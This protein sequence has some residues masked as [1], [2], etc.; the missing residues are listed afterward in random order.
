[1]APLPIVSQSGVANRD[2]F[3]R[4]VDY[5]RL[6]LTD[7]CNLRCTYC[8]PA[9]GV[10]L[11]PRD[12]LLTFEEIWRVAA[13]AQALGFQKFRITGGEPLVVRDIVRFV[14]GLRAVVGSSKIAMTTNAVRLAPLA[15]PLREAGLQLLNISCDTLQADRFARIARRSHLEDMLQGIDAALAAGFERVKLNVVVMPGVNDDEL[16]ALAG[17]AERFDVDVRFIEAMPQMGE[18]RAFVA[19]ETMLDK[20]REAYDLSEVPPK[21]ARQAARMVYTA[22]GL[23]GS[24]AFIAPLTHKFCAQCNRMRLTPYGELKGCLLTP[25]GMGLRDTLRSGISDTNL[26]LL[27]GSAILHKPWAYDDDHHG[28]DRSMSAIGG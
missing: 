17:F 7:R 8:M 25:G 3:G 14:S 13:A 23:L 4:Q 18:A 5:L 9:E 16:V 6:S 26:Q 21:D 15:R 2:A 10:A 1:M 28:L 19:A 27:I 22:P 24:L 12:Q 11:Q 20:L